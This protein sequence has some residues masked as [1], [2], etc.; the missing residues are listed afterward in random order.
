MA[1]VPIVATFR[2]DVHAYPLQWSEARVRTYRLYRELRKRCS[3]LDA[4]HAIGMTL[5]IWGPYSALVP[6]PADRFEV[7]G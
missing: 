2:V 1:V 3:R 5:A 4:R 6:R 7:S